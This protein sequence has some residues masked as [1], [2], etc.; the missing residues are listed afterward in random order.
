[1]I[2]YFKGNVVIVI[3]LFQ[4]SHSHYAIIPL[5]KFSLISFHYS[6]SAPTLAAEKEMRSKA[7]TNST[8]SI[9]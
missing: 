4:K 3:L 1:M 5:Q 2:T 9:V 7:Q 8:I 6:S